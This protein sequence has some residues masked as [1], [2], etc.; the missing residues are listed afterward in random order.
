MKSR[1][2]QYA[3]SLEVVS[4]SIMVLGFGMLFQPWFHFAFRYSVVVMLLGLVMFNV[5][6]RLPQHKGE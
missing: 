6:S 1:I 2:Y 4:L 3:Y 5:F